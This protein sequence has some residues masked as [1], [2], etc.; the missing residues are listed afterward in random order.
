MTTN[1]YIYST[2]RVW[3]SRPPG[4][5][6]VTIIVPGELSPF[7]AKKTAREELATDQS[8]M[9]VAGSSSGGGSAAC[10]GSAV[11]SAASKDDDEHDTT[12]TM[13]SHGSTGIKRRRLS[14]LTA[15]DVGRLASV[16]GLTLVP[17]RHSATG[18]RGVTKDLRRDSLWYVSYQ[19]QYLGCFQS[20][21]E[22]ALAFA[23]KLG[24]EG[25]AA[26]AARQE[27]P[28]HA[29]EAR[30]QA[31]AEGLT[32]VQLPGT[33]GGFK[34]VKMS[35]QSPGQRDVFQAVFKKKALGRFATAEEAALAYARCEAREEPRK[36][37]MEEQKRRVEEEKRK[38]QERSAE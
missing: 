10:D 12:V 19:E 16:E 18:F 27:E 8:G 17:S 23:R 3:Y 34:G 6:L 32:L 24:P 37:D 2:V 15:E 36:L 11:S 28:M 25:S 13:A 35:R 14:A 20:V 26:A 1:I 29:E 9:P 31:A 21:H 22:A 4:Q 7:Q 5:E 38:A 30:S 33:Q